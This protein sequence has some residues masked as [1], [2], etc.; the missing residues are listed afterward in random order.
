MSIDTL[1]RRTPTAASSLAY[2]ASW[3]PLVVSV[4]SS[5]APLSRC[6]PSP[7]N[8]DITFL[9]TSGS[10]PVSR[11]FLTPRRTK[12]RAQPL[13]LLER[14]DLGLGQEGHVLGHAIDAAEVAAVRHRDAQVGDVPAERVDHAFN[15]GRLGPYF[16][17]KQ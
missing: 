14:Q 10:P 16:D 11:S 17:P 6:R 9:R 4:S 3:L 7:R 15:V 12:A 2:L 13:Q 5:S 8:S 1:T